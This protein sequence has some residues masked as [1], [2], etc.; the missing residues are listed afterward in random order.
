IG[1]ADGIGAGA[2]PHLAWSNDGRYLF[3]PG[4]DSA[5]KH[6]L[7]IVRQDT[8]TGL[9]R[10]ITFP[11]TGI[12]GDSSVAMSPDGSKLAFARTLTLT[13]TDIYTIPLSE[14]YLPTHAPEKI[15]SGVGV[16]SLAWTA[17]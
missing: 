11:P 5:K 9:T 4:F 16:E 15:L 8:Q 12:W 7:A 1:R 10:Q 14:D 13:S 6:L 17:D 3:W 2:P